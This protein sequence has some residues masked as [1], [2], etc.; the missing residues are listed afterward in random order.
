MKDATKSLTIGKIVYQ[1]LKRKGRVTPPNL[2]E[3]EQGNIIYDPQVAMDTIANKWDSVFAVN[4][5]HEHEMQILKQIWPYIHDKGKAI[6]LPPITEQQLWQQASRRR[7]DAAAGLDGWMTREVQAL[8]PSAFRPVASLFN[9]IEAGSAEFPTVLT[10]V[11]MVIHNKDGSDAPLSKRL[12]SLQS[13]FT[14]LYTG[15]RFMQLQNWQQEIMPWLQGGIKGRQMTEVHMTIQMEIDSAHSFHGCF[16]GL[17]L[18]KSKC[19]DRLIPK[20]CA[21]LML[22][23]GLPRGVVCGFLALYSRMTRYLSFKQWTR[24][25]PI[26][27]ANGVVQGC[28]FSLLCINL[29]MAVWA[30][31]IENLQGVQFRAFI[32]DTYLWSRL[33]SIDQLVAAVRATELWDQLCGQ[34]LNASK[35]ELFATTAPCAQLCGML[36]HRC[37]WLK[38]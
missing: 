27:T 25:Q 21:A 29:H 31:I 3:D 35:C 12:I 14:L 37:K 20:L 1:F 6:T 28:S 13:V 11:R 4:T 10:Q 19:F 5:E 23:L 22:A 30:W 32:D 38:W 33:P 26:S 15:L 34:F 8:P 17:K 24:G 7:P 2:V 16:S 18:D 36:F 9:V